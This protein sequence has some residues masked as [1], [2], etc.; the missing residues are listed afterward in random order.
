MLGST[1]SLQDA[2][3]E[4]ELAQLWEIKEKVDPLGVLVGNYPLP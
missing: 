4:P 2:F 1:A 3:T